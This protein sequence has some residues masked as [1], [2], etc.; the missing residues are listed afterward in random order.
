[1]CD[2]EKDIWDNRMDEGSRICFGSSPQQS[3]GG[4]VHEGE[5]AGY[6]PSTLRLK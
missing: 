2:L 1:M 3:G 4:T 6:E 5:S